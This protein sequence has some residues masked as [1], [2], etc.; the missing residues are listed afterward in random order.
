MAEAVAERGIRQG[1]LPSP[2]PWIAVCTFFIIVAT[3]L[4]AYSGLR[5]A[6]ETQHELRLIPWLPYD[7]RVD[8]GYF[9]A[10]AYMA[11]RGEAFDL[12]P[13]PGEITVYPGDPIFQEFDSDYVR[14]RL[15]GRG[16]FYNPPALAYILSPLTTL[17]FR[18]AYWLFSAIS[19]SALVGFV[20]LS[21][22]TGR[23]VGEMPLLILGVLSFKPVHE[24]VIMAHMTLFFILA[25]TAGFL[26]L[27]AEKP[28]LAGLVLSSSRTAST[29]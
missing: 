9:Y 14:A 21:V 3:V 13:N 22:W 25:L 26:L 23:R 28:L 1:I 19:I 11:W 5:F 12:Y 8:F 20:G 29:A 2:S 18:D 17:S 4:F 16:N 15:M 6:K 10:G 7:M 24:A 27:R